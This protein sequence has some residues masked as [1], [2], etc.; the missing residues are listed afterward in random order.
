MSDSSSKAPPVSNA[1][2]WMDASARKKAQYT[3]LFTVFLDILGFS[4][5]IP[6]LA[7][8]AAQF[9]ATPWMTGVLASV[10]SM[11]GFL[12]TPVWGRLSDLH[13][14]RPILLFS[15]FGTAMGYIAFALAHSLPFLF[16]A[17]VIDGITGGNISTAQA[18]L[19]DIT[20]PEDR[21]KSYGLF[22]AT[23][24]IAFAI[25]PLIGSALSHLPGAWGGNFGLGMFSMTL[26][27]LNLALASKFLPETLSP[28]IIARNRAQPS[29][30]SPISGYAKTLAIPRL[31]TVILIGFLATTAFATIQGIYAVYILKEYTRPLVQQEIARNPQAAIDRA[32][33]LANAEPSTTASIGAGEGASLIPAGGDDATTPY[34]KSLGGDYQGPQ[35][36]GAAGQQT[37]ALPEGLSWRH[38]EK[39]LV[40]PESARVVGQIFGVIG[41]LSLFIQGGLMRKLP[42]KVGEVP[43]VVVGTVIM[44]VGL[45]SVSLMSHLAPHQLWGQFLASA[46]LTLGN[47]LSTPV[48]TSLASQFAPEAERGEALGVYQSTQSLGRIVGPNLGGISFDR[49]APSA[50]FVAGALIMLVAAGMALQLRAFTPKREPANAS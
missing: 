31:N 36:A 41:L 38:V 3:I 6:Q 24:G 1:T 39:L 27:L 28:D 34:D 43:L 32:R 29:P 50:P 23:F 44:A 35:R 37:T 9:G 20:P 42:Q 47:G 30:P 16:L 40:R 33:Q 45:F 17:R 11:M 14:R 12:F 26:G 22:G 48:L 4:I 25:G 7:V 8:Y 18:Y 15:I 46:I 5:I 19:S 49:I 13:G 21:S 10:Y 2:E